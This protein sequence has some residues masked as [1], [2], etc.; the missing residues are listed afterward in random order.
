MPQQE[1]IHEVYR[2]A[3]E[4]TEAQIRPAFRMPEFSLN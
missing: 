1:F 3:R 4:R 2:V